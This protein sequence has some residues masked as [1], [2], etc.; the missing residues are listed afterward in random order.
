MIERPEIFDIRETVAGE[1]FVERLRR[2]G[3]LK[4]ATGVF[5]VGCGRGGT[6]RALIGECSGYVGVDDFSCHN[7]PQ[8]FPGNF[9]FWDADV[10]HEGWE[11]PPNIFVTDLAILVAASQWTLKNAMKLNPSVIIAPGVQ[12]T[13][14]APGYE[15]EW[16][17]GDTIFRKVDDAQ[18]PV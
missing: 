3:I 16:P 17:S 8:G 9:R 15:L 18:R 4:P 12:W 2:H 6:A 1:V 14:D 7:K 10:C 5:E 11:L 13:T